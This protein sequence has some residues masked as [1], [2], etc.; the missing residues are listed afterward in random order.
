[1]LH[2]VFAEM[3]TQYLKDTYREMREDA[4]RNDGVILSTNHRDI[5]KKIS[6][7][8]MQPVSTNLMVAEI[9]VYKELLKRLI[10]D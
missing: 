6:Q 8:N 1:M 4:Q 2:Q 7:F 10:E 9:M 5:S 3:S